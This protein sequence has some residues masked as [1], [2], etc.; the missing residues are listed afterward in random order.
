MIG[1]NHANFHIK[2]VQI[3]Q[4]INVK[5]AP[6]WRPQKIRNLWPFVVQFVEP[7][8]CF[9]AAN[10]RPFCRKLTVKVAEG[11]WDLV[12]KS[13][14][15]PFAFDLPND[16]GSAYVPTLVPPNSAIVGLK[17]RL[18]I[19]L[20]RKPVYFLCSRK[21]YYIKYI[22]YNNLLRAKSMP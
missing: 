8:F 2:N 7:N 6:F 22:L 9:L 15:R 12:L 14:R 5:F 4:K 10:Y 20:S 19:D 17:N 21:I 13:P 16:R 11:V 18:K 1:Q 3:S